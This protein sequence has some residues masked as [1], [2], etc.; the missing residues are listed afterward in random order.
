[1]FL[2]YLHIIVNNIFCA[3]IPITMYVPASIYIIT[4]CNL[5]FVSPPGFLSSI[6]K[7]RCHFHY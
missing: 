1:M 3:L 6:K 5:A 4:W 7:L 2:A